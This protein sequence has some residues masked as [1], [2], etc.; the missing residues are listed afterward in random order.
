MGKFTPKILS[1]YEAIL[2]ENRPEK[3]VWSEFFL[4][5][6]H[7]TSLKGILT[8][9]SA[10]YPAKE[11]LR[12]SID[13]LLA[14]CAEN[15]RRTSGDIR[16]INSCTTLCV[17][18]ETLGEK[19]NSGTT[20]SQLSNLCQ[21][22]IEKISAEEISDDEDK[23][24]LR[25]IFL[26]MC[27]NKA[28]KESPSIECFSKGVLLFDNILRIFSTTQLDP[29]ILRGAVLCIEAML[30]HT[31]ISPT[32]HLSAHLTSLQETFVISG[33]IQYI[34]KWMTAYNNT[35]RGAFVENESSFVSSISNTVFNLFSNG[36]S[37]DVSLHA[38]IRELNGS[39]C[40]LLLYQATS[41][42]WKFLN[43]FISPLHDS[44]LPD[45][46][47]ACTSA[48]AT[49]LTFNSF[50]FNNFK[51]DV[52][53][54]LSKFCLLTLWN[55][56]NDQPSRHLLSEMK[57]FPILLFKPASLRK[58][59]TCVLDEE[60]RPLSEYVLNLLTDFCVHHLMLHFP[61]D[62]YHIALSTIHRILIH[63]KNINCRIKR[64]NPLFEALIALLN[65]LSHHYSRLGTLPSLKLAERALGLINFFITYGDT[66]LPHAASYDF[67]YYE[68]VRQSDV[69]NR[70]NST[71]EEISQNAKAGSA[72]AES[73]ERL[74]NQLVNI[75][76][77]IK[78]IRPKL[79][80][81]SFE[82]ANPDE[83][84]KESFSDLTL[85]LYEGLET[86]EKWEES[87]DRDAVL[88]SLIETAMS[89]V[90]KSP[91]T[92]CNISVA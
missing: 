80:S 58:R 44:Q 9:I 35:C 51:S 41:C 31:G 7:V 2:L 72:F 36:E 3:I 89:S 74:V 21:S 73:S 39:E 4:V 57:M 46:S 42:N 84:I 48:F 45:S 15:I 24:L 59:A 68:I 37:S 91:G 60:C 82:N 92:I 25:T 23:W 12:A 63:Q 86:V 43:T 26:I 65:Y 40:L 28:L 34:N 27:S 8:K 87:A 6:P 67:L 56:I 1:L 10:D 14:K 52:T 66:F 76:A 53:R 20:C 47:S 5:K 61:F 54:N 11:C 79:E 90:R 70:L 32:N 78:H 81:V 19:I 64:C 62:H 33:L 71:A 16:I 55:V 49:F 69:F 75:L 50:L 13:V 85:K 83:V 30:Q 29:S 38:E 88:C 77:I 22:L 17:V 18:F